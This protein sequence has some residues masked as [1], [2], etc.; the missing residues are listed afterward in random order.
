M[1]NQELESILKELPQVDVPFGGPVP[2]AN[3]YICVSGGLIQIYPNI[4][5]W[6][7]LPIDLARADVAPWAD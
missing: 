1:Y 5:G 4:G 2:N 3:A 6:L 7:G